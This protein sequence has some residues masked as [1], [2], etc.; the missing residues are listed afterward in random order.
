MP[1]PLLVAAAT[2]LGANLVGRLTPPK[3]FVP[4]G[5]FS[6]SYVDNGN[7]GV[8]DEID[9][10]LASGYANV[11]IDENDI[12][13]YAPFNGGHVNNRGTEAYRLWMDGINSG[14]FL[15]VPPAGSASLS[16]LRFTTLTLENL[17]A[18]APDS[19]EISITIMKHVDQV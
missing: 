14:R 8:V 5:G 3:T 6:K 18:T 7:N 9:N 10:I 19:G 13:K 12:N 4:I 16:N 1:N 2:L 17:D 11:N 15:D